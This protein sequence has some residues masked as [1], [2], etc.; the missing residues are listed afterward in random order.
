MRLMRKLLCF[1][2]FCLKRS[3]KIEILK[4]EIFLAKNH[5]IQI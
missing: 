1:S 5:E 2:F 4:G 3:F